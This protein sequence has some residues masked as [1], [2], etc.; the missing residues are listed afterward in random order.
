[1]DI[2]LQRDGTRR[3]AH[4]QPRGD[5]LAITLDDGVVRSVRVV[6]L[7]EDTLLLEIDGVR[8]RLRWARRGRE[9]HVSH[10]GRSAHLHWVEEDEIDET[11]A[12]GSPIVRAPMP[13]RVL[14]ITVAV[15]DAVEEG[16]VVARLEAMKMELSL[17]ASVAGTVAAVHVAA[18]D[19]VEPDAPIVTV[20]GEADAS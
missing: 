17:T 13:G 3:T 1:M 10:R 12:V 19:L 15:G 16:Q 2:D 11:S 6:A 14:E 7:E 20:D 8:R 5:D 4:V 18:A 9:V